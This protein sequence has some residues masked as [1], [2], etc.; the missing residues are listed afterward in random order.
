MEYHR[1]NRRGRPRSR[2]RVP[3]YIAARPPKWSVFNGFCSF[4][5]LTSLIA[6]MYLML[7]F[8]CNNCSKK[9]NI[10]NITKGLDDIA[11]N[12]SN[13]KGSYSDLERKITKFSEE[14]PKIEGQIEIL[15]ALANTMERGDWVWNPKAHLAL[16][17]VDVYLSKVP[18]NNEKSLK[19]LNLKT[20]QVNTEENLTIN[21]ANMS[22]TVSKTLKKD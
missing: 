19:V 18:K 7:E 22:S 12:I 17:N 9:C 14:L 21:D 16:P 13:M 4:L 6:I 8:H 1:R 3:V 11:L 20:E 15:E 10:Y 5:V 2:P